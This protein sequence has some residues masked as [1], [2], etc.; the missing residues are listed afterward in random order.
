MFNAHVP[1]GNSPAFPAIEAIELR[2]RAN[3][4]PQALT[5]P[6]AQSVSAPRLDGTLLSSPS[7]QENHDLNSAISTSQTARDDELSQIRIASAEASASTPS[8]VSSSQRNEPQPPALQIPANKK[9]SKTAV[10][11]LAIAVVFG[12]GA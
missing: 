2:Q 1:C 8:P 7:Q 9:W 6:L 10:L 5:A 3:V 12:I 4:S 11:A